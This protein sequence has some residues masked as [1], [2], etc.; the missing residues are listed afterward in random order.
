MTDVQGGG[1]PIGHEALAPLP[2]SRG[3]AIVTER[4]PGWETLTDSIAAGTEGC[5]MACGLGFGD[6]D[7]GD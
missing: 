5:E 6:Q 7:L 1:A 3:G 4:I 2:G